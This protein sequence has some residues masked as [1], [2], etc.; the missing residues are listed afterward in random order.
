MS[1]HGL[2]KDEATW[3]KYISKIISKKM[4]EEPQ[5][6]LTIDLTKKNTISV[7]TL[8]KLQFNYENS[9]EAR[10]YNLAKTMKTALDVYYK[11]M[12]NKGELCP[13]IETSLDLENEEAIKALRP[14]SALTFTQYMK[15]HPETSA[16]PVKRRK[17]VK[18]VLR[19]P[20]K[21]I[22]YKDI[23]ITR[24]KMK[25]EAKKK[26]ILKYNFLSAKEL[27]HQEMNI[28]FEKFCPNLE[29]PKALIPTERYGRNNTIKPGAFDKYF[30]QR[31]SEIRGSLRNKSTQKT[32]KGLTLKSINDNNNILRVRKRRN[33]QEPVKNFGFRYTHPKDTRITK[34]SLQPSIST[35]A[36]ASRKRSSWDNFILKIQPELTI[37]KS[38]FI[39]FYNIPRSSLK[40]R[41]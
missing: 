16:D 21:Y 17:M 37:S 24:Q 29:V 28:G 38:K 8:E 2:E 10:D 14:Q 15:K 30:H 20:K 27:F 4:V 13:E 7:P 12:L 35:Q 41:A 36:P 25:S 40:Q 39:K 26:K 3:L 9:Q 34:R 1:N 23:N 33:S 11:E 31:N 18:R 32:K 5:E 6:R 22:Y 19:N